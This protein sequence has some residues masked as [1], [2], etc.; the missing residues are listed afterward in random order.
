M[1]GSVDAN[2]GDLLLGW[3]TDQFPLDVYDTIGA[4][5]VILS[6]GGLSPGGLNFDAKVR[7]SSTSL[8]D[9]FHAHI[10]G[11]DSFALALKVAHRIREDGALGGHVSKRYAGY[12]NGIG[13]RIENR[14]VTFR[15][16]EQYVFEH[17]EP[18]PRSGQQ[19]RLEN[20]VNQ[21]LARVIREG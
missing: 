8:K 6:Q 19:E 10:G 4:M 14:E 17:G 21:Y 12:D 13:N 7:R 20:V 15:E 9:I 16:L 18:E 2:R 5:L 1:L 3:D 11:M